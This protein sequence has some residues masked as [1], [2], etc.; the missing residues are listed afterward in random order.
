MID[1]TDRKRNVI[2]I[3][4]SSFLVLSYDI[5]HS[6]NT[7]KQFGISGKTHIFSRGVNPV[8]LNI[9]AICCV[10]DMSCAYDLENALISAIENVF[11]IDGISFSGM[12]LDGYSINCDKNGCVS[13][14]S[15]SFSSAEC[16]SE[17][18][19]NE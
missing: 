15:L 6:R 12:V 13:D 16:I 1:F 14:I 5:S 17:V 2:N 7:I 10:S 11:T 19:Q 3:L 4:N 9:K 18:S 8:F